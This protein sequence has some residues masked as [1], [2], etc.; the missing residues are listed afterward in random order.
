MRRS[1]KQSKSDFS[2]NVFGLAKKTLFVQSLS[3]F[4]ER[5][6]GSF[7]TLWMEFNQ[8]AKRRN[9][10][11][12][13][14]SREGGWVHF[15]LSA[16]GSIKT[17]KSATVPS[18]TFPEREGE[19]ISNFP[20]GDQSKRINAQLRRTQCFQKGR[21]DSFRTFWREFNQNAQKRNIAILNVSGE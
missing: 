5:R 11:I 2:R 21:A 18:S 15:G 10:V 13:N 12:L 19:L 7:R 1:I 16:G 17:N 20:G 9:C 3:D 8:N 4:L 6:V 14:V